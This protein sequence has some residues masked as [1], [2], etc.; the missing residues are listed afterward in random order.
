L[1]GVVWVCVVGV[2]G[3]VWGGLGGEKGG[4]GWGGG[5]GGGGGGGVRQGQLY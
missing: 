1:F 4:V 5:G 3:L 2:G